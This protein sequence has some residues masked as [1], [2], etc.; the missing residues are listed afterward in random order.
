M[1]AIATIFAIFP[2]SLM[3]SM[4]KRYREED[5]EDDLDFYPDYGEV[6]F[7]NYENGSIWGFI[8]TS[9]LVSIL[10]AFAII[11]TI[12]IM[13]MVIANIDFDLSKEI[14]SWVFDNFWY[15]TAPLLI[16]IGL[17]INPIGYLIFRIRRK[18]QLPQE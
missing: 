11:I 2:P 16:G 15:G 18:K 6:K 8:S 5:T 12:I 10:T 17:L 3:F 7:W 14:D 9:L 4:W 1:I 13:L